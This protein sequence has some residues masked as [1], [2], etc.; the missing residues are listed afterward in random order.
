MAAAG[1]TVTGWEANCWQ[2]QK[3][4]EV[5]KMMTIVAGCWS[6]SVLDTAESVTHTVSA[7][8]SSVGLGIYH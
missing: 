2:R 5:L 4:G 1:S 8:G 3:E 7:P 6:Y